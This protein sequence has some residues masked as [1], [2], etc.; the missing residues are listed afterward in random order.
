MPRQQRATLL[1]YTTLFR[2]QA[3]EYQ[4]CVRV[5]SEG[6]GLEPENREFQGLREQAQQALAKIRKVQELMQR[7]EQQQR[8]KDPQAVWR[9]TEELDR[10]STRLNSSH[11][12]KS[13]AVFCLKKQRKIE[14]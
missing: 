4:A 12:V 8:K 1:P 6:L 5:A 3:E 9:T 11:T 13:Y 2:S 10:K 7:A 14:G